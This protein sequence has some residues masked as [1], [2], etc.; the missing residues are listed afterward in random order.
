M[1]AQRG[2]KKKSVFSFSAPEEDP[3]ESFVLNLLAC[4]DSFV[5][6]DQQHDIEITLVAPNGPGPEG[7]SE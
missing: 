1:A 3:G 4:S 6:L 5:G 7:R 2:R